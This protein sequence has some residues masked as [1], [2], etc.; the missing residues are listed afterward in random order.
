MLNFLLFA[1]VFVLSL[2]VYSYSYTCNGIINT[3]TAFDFTF[4]QN[5]VVMD[6][7]GGPPHFEP[8]LF[9]Y[10]A[11]KYFTESFMRYRVDEWEVNLEFFDYKGKKSG[12]ESK[13]VVTLD[14]RFNKTFRYQD[15]KAFEIREGKAI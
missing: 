13:A 4:A 14:C 1:A 7:Y 3:F 11:S 2:S 8:K 9:Y 10:I 12:P 15:C 6:I 5:A